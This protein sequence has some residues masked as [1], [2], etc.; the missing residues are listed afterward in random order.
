VCTVFPLEI[1]QTTF[2]RAKYLSIWPYLLLFLERPT[3]RSFNFQQLDHLKLAKKKYCWNSLAKTARRHCQ[4]QNRVSAW[5]TNFIYWKFVYGNK[6]ELDPRVMLMY[7][8]RDLTM[9][10]GRAAPGC[11]SG[12]RVI[13]SSCE[14]T[15]LVI[16]RF[17]YTTINSCRVRSNR[18]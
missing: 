11:R 1:N 3:F 12:S 17:V 10:V 16:H 13:N 7:T 15:F 9:C 6:N 5:I 2:S 4:S 8:K 18:A 14:R